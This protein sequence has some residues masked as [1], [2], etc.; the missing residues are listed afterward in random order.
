[1]KKNVEILLMI[2][3]SCCLIG[4]SSR[5]LSNNEVKRIDATTVEVLAQFDIT[6]CEWQIVA[7]GGAYRAQSLDDEQTVLRGDSL[8]GEYY[9]DGISY[10]YSNGE[11]T[12]CENDVFERSRADAET[13]LNCIKRCF[14]DSLFDSIEPNAGIEGE[15]Y[16][17]Y[18]VNEEGL[19]LFKAVDDKY[20]ECRI[21]IDVSQA[22]DFESCSLRLKYGSSSWDVYAYGEIIGRM[23]ITAPY[24]K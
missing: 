10:H 8:N 1:M 4:C 14:E 2:L 19:A 17:C 22:L 5:V 13:M 12:R 11:V 7:D 16:V 21:L 6:G 23:V 9:A 24:S 20:T 18:Q 3:L 15:W